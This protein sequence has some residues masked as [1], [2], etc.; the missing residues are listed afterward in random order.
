VSQIARTRV[1]HIVVL[2]LENRSFDHLFAYL[3][4]PPVD[5]YP[6][7][8][9]L[10]D[11]NSPVF[12]I[13]PDGR[14]DL[15][16]D[17]PH[18]HLSVMKQLNRGRMN[19]FVAAYAEKA[20]GKEELPIIHWWRLE[21]LVVLLAAIVPTAG[22]LV[23]Y[24]WPT[25]ILVCLGVASLGTY[26]LL[27][28]PKLSGKIWWA[29]EISV[30][31]ASAA[32]AIG[33]R[34]L[35]LLLR[36]RGIAGWGISS[37]V[38][39]VLGSAALAYFCSRPRYKKPPLSVSDEQLASKIMRCMSRDRIPVL[40]RLADEFAVCTQ[41]HSS[42]PGAT[43]PNR[44]FAHAAT[45]SGTTDIEVGLYD[46]PTIFE[47]LEAAGRSWSV[48]YHDFAQLLAFHKLW[49]VGERVNNWR[50]L[51]HFKLDVSLGRL[52][53]YVFIEPNHRGDGSNSQHPGNNTAPAQDG[54]YDF[55]RG[56]RLIR[57]VYE[58]LRSNYELFKKTLLLITY[59]EHGGTFDHVPPKN[60]KAPTIGKAATS[61][62]R[63]LISAFVTYRGTRFH[64]NMLGVRVPAVVVSPWIAKNRGNDPTLYD[65]SSIVAS[66]RALHMPGSSPLTRRDRY[67]ND[68]LH[69]VEESEEARPAD[70]L[71]PM[72]PP[73]VGVPQ[74]PAGGDATPS[75]ASAPP[76]S[77]AFK[78][79]KANDGFLDLEF[80]ALAELVRKRLEQLGVWPPQSVATL[81][82]EL[83]SRRPYW[84]IAFALHDLSKQR[85]STK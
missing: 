66:V 71:P 85:P 76:Y 23:G 46:D 15:P 57:D 48:Y 78:G 49:D 56:E 10:H 2:M 72:P 45:S 3:D 14:Y 75:V 55:E 54:S 65:H 77:T 16:L 13:N 39:A 12:D 63:R 32:L 41:W 53:D 81:G 80:D 19:G 60:A 52:S 1:E 4:G 42:V 20:I 17:P 18:S 34:G 64:F 84:D 59:D 21:G 50:D 69:L 44:N 29:A 11:K 47:Q 5:P 22:W 25:S 36:G 83:T 31:T 68:F 30:L 27:R 28:L 8:L 58:A 7:P 62:T 43:W 37:G 26:A 40:A 6:N 79:S 38:L 82:Q 35:H 33:A 73:L 61:W 67:A 24:G 9:D 74:P 51:S 70:D